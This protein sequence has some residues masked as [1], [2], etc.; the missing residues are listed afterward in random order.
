MP[1]TWLTVKE[2][3]IYLKVHYT[4]VRRYVKLGKLKAHKPGGKLVRIC[5]EELEKLGEEATDEPS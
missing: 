2:A 5:L 4:T 1:C 3:A